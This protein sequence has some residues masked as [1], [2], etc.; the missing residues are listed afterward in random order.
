[1]K[2][3]P[4]EDFEVWTWKSCVLL[5][6]YHHQIATCPQVSSEEPWKYTFFP[7]SRVALWRV[8]NNLYHKILS[9]V[10]FLP[11]PAL[12]KINQVNLHS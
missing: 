4:E 3:L 11:I 10:H 8:N 7:E 5:L 12:Q 9:P 2:E 1:M 6:T